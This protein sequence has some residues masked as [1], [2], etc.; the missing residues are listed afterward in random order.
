[1]KKTLLLARDRLG[2][3]PLFYAIID[4]RLAFGSE[5]KAILQ[6][7]E[8]ERKLNWTS[9]NHL[10]SAMCTP[11]SESIVAGVHKLRPGHILTASPRHPIQIRQ[12]WDVE[13]EPDYN[14]S[15]QFFVDRLRDLL[16]ESVRLRMIADVPLGAFLSG[17]I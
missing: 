15:E 2:I 16:E 17:G 9:V 3:K 11:S 12:Y 14:K 7:S 1:R 4:G 10:F 6:L 5:L 13:Y 8:V